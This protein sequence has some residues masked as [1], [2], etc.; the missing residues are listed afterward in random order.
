MQLTYRHT[1]Y[2]AYL[3]YVTQAIVN[4]LSPLLFVTFKTSFGIPLEKLGILASVNFG[5][6]IIVD[7]LSVKYIDRIGY[8]TGAVLAHGFAVIGLVCLGVLPG[9]M[10]DIYA[11]LLIATVLSAI[12]GG[13]TEVLISPIIES[14]PGDEKASAMSLL[15]SFYC[16]G[17][18]AVVLLSTL[19]FLAAGIA[20]WRLLPV[21]WAIVPLFNLFFF[22]RVPLRVLVEESQRVP[23]RKLFQSRIFWLFLALMVCAGASEQAMSQWASLFAQSGLHVLKT[24]GDLLGPGMFAVAMGLSRLL[25]GVFGSRLNVRHG[26][27]GSAA[28]CIASYLIVVLSPWAIFSLF[29]CTLCGFSVGLMWPGTF[30]LAAKDYAAGGTAMFALLALAGDL[31]CSAGP[32]VVGAVSGWMERLNAG[33]AA[34]R[35]GI[36]VAIAFPVL[37]LIGAF[38][39]G[40]AEKHDSR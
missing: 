32:G 11:A 24:A 13:L 31:G 21:L 22:T 29:G 30:S 9:V 20:N 34:L 16:W 5:V 15:H 38:A 17:H 3:G 35:I 10:T 6:Q 23:V 36:A 40:K 33:S 1:K 12:G 19:Y 14:L 4:N 7:F 2:A 25:Y 37:L 18:V 26:L 27:I 8:R 28:L 39:L